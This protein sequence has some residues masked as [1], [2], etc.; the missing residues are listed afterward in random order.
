MALNYEYDRIPEIDEIIKLYAQSGLPRPIQDRS[1]MVEMYENSDLIIT[2]WDQ[3]K[4]VGICRCVTDWVWCCYLSDLAVSP[5]YQESGIG[6]KMIEMT[7]DKVSHQCMILLLSVPTAMDYYPKVG[8]N[9]E[10]RA[11]SIN[12]A[13]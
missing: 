12:R 8:F 7:R 13:E 10:N 4:L 6:R 2:A 1:R 5:D 3:D 9:K 11:F